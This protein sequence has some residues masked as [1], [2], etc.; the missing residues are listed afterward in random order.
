M[1]FTFFPFTTTENPFLYLF[2]ASFGGGGQKEREGGRKHKQG[3]GR[4]RKRENPKQVPCS[5]Q[6][7]T[8][9]S[10]PPSRDHDLS[11]HQESDTQLTEPPQAPLICL[12]LKAN[13]YSTMYPQLGKE[14][15][16]HKKS[17]R[18]LF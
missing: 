11:R 1:I 9:G 7:P 17:Q 15:A 10:I 2:A 13:I 18:A 6:S 3:R 4:E 14:P 16:G 5:A 8:Q 12:V